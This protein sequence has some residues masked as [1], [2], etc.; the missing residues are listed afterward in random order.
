MRYKIRPVQAWQW[1]GSTLE[2]Q[3]LPSWMLNIH[4]QQ[5]SDRLVVEGA[6]NMRRHDWLVGHG[7]GACSI[8]GNDEFHTTFEPSNGQP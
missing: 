7:P 3:T 6:G 4:I 5:H 2:E 1:N 8:F